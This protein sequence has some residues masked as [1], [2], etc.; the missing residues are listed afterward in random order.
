MSWINTIDEAPPTNTNFLF[1]AKYKYTLPQSSDPL[2]KHIGFE[3]GAGHICGDIVLLGGGDE[4]YYH[5]SD[6]THWQ[7]LPAPPIT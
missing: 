7:P 2:E 4:N 1:H 3:I 5:L 6:I